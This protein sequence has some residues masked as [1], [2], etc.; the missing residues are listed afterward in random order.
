MVRSVAQRRRRR[1]RWRRA[2]P[3][4]VDSEAAAAAAAASKTTTTQTWRTDRPP[5]IHAPR[6]HPHTPCSQRPPRRPRSRP[7]RRSLRPRSSR[8][9]HKASPFIPP[10]RSSTTRM[11]T[12]L[13]LPPLLV[14]LSTVTRKPRRWPLLMITVARLPSPAVPTRTPPRRRRANRTRP[15]LRT[16]SMRRRRRQG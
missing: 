12:I 6:T 1:L 3:E 8:S 7:L 9:R 13:L 11:S 4:Q 15:T 16:K 14:L 2:R 10:L 5:Q